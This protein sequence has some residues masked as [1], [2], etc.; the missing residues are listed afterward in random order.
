LLRPLG[1]W[2]AKE[3]LPELQQ[4][5]AHSVV[6]LEPPEPGMTLEPPL[7]EQ[8]RSESELVSQPVSQPERAEPEVQVL[9]GI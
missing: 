5:R 4:Q 8:V 7:R 3:G 9:P 2:E 6:P 1:H